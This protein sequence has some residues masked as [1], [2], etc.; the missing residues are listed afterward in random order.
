MYDKPLAY[1]L[2][3][4]TYGTWLHG[5]PTNSIIRRNGT[6]ELMESNPFLFQ[7]EQSRLKD[8]PVNLQADQ[9]PLVLDT[10]LE[11]IKIRKWH[12]F[13]LH[14]RSNHVH[15]VVKAGDRIDLVMDHLKRWSTRRL[16][17]NGFHYKK[18]WTSKG[19]RKYMFRPEKLR[20]KIHYVIYEQGTMMAYY[21]DERFRK[22]G[23]ISGD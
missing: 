5:D 21:I 3:F 13:A 20:E 15:A 10:I 9:W 17:E 6:A 14:V 22:C 8:P 11:V 18:V 2:T 4:T 7:Y 16:R 19:S 1:F 23:V 12:P